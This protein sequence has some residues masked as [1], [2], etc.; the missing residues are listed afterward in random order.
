MDKKV[1][2]ITEEKQKYLDLLKD[3]FK[4]DIKFAYALHSSLMALSMRKWGYQALRFLPSKKDN[5][6]WDWM[7]EYPCGDYDELV[8]VTIALHYPEIY[9]GL[10]SDIPVSIINEYI[11]KNLY[12]FT[13]VRCNNK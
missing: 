13:I 5:K 11:T 3:A 9:E 1:F 7:Q 4:E 6:G 8:M 10:K 2:I 12:P